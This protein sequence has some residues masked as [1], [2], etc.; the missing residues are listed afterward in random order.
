[1]CNIKLLGSVIYLYGE[2]G[3]FE[4]ID[5]NKNLIGRSMCRFC[6]DQV[7]VLFDLFVLHM[8][9]CHAYNTG[10]AQC[11]HIPAVNTNLADIAIRYKG[12]LLWNVM[13]CKGVYPDT[14]LSNF[15]RKLSC[16]YEGCQLDIIIFLQYNFKYIFLK[17]C[18]ETGYSMHS[19]C[20]LSS[21]KLIIF[22]TRGH[23]WFGRS[24]LP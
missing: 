10:S 24:N 14:Y 8:C 16:C 13:I 17:L 15:S 4:L 6:N 18:L 22:W 11:F 3:M 1:M 20:V 7:S 21:Y 5:I 19:T 12:P 9:E 2:M 23:A